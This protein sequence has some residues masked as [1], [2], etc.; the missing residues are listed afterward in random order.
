MNYNYYTYI[1]V[2]FVFFNCDFVFIFCRI[3]N[4]NCLSD[5]PD[6]VIYLELLPCSEKSDVKSSHRVHVLRNLEMSDLT[7]FREEIL[8]RLLLNGSGRQDLRQ[9]GNAPGLRHDWVMRQQ[10][11]I[12]IGVLLPWIFLH[13]WCD[14]LRL[15]RLFIKSPNNLW[16]WM[17]LL[18]LESLNIPLC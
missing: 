5:L 17:F 11:W 14:D 13:I 1:L 15:H 12:L 3:D 9:R 18:L 10:I 6:N 2:R 4:F 7:W 16:L 8:N